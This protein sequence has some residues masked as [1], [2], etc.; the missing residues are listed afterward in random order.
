MDEFKRVPF[1]G[2]PYADFEFFKVELKACDV[3][4]TPEQIYAHFEFTNGCKVDVQGIFYPALIRKA[5]IQVHEM[6]QA[7]ITNS[8][9]YGIHADN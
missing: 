5:V 9:R 6:E 1:G 3:I 4:Y 7:H 2:N 8:S